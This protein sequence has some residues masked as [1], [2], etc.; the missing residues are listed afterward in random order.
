MVA[1][2]INKLQFPPYQLDERIPQQTAAYDNN[3]RRRWQS[4]EFVWPEE[5]QAAYPKGEYWWLYGRPR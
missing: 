3:L 5:W 4:G 1:A 2:L